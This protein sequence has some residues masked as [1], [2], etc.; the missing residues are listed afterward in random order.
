MGIKINHT[1]I[2]IINL[3]THYRINMI[4]KTQII[5]EKF[6]EQIKIAWKKEKLKFWWTIKKAFKLVKKRSFLIKNA[7]QKRKKK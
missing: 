4:K 7:N 2:N 6:Y 3:F 1:Q 5:N